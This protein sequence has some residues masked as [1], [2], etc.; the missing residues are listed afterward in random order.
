MIKKLIYPALILLLQGLHVTSL[1]LVYSEV[2][3][4]INHD[5]AVKFLDAWLI[6]G[7]CL[8][9]LSLLVIF[10]NRFKWYNFIIIL[11]DLFLILFYLFRMNWEPGA[12]L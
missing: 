1:V 5:A 9:V 12:M 2:F 6:A 3:F 11:Y 8:L 10:M 4:K 7:A